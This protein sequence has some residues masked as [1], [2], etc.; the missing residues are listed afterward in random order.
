MA[1]HRGSDIKGGAGHEISEAG[2]GVKNLPDCPTCRYGT[3]DMHPCKKA[4]MMCID[5]GA[6]YTVAHLV[7]MRVLPRSA[8]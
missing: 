7:E 1:I 6:E 2:S 4:H 8:L 3:L 5:C